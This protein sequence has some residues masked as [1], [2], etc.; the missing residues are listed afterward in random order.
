MLQSAEEPVVRLVDQCI[1]NEHVCYGDKHVLLH[2]VMPWNSL[3]M[4]I[5]MHPIIGQPIN[6]SLCVY[7]VFGQGNLCSRCMESE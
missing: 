6:L 3:L 7:A 2:N 4:W 1:N 5:I